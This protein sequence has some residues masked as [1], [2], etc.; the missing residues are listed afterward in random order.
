[1]TVSLLHY[2]NGIKYKLQEHL[3]SVEIIFPSLLKYCPNNIVRIVS[4]VKNRT[5]LREYQAGI[6]GSTVVFLRILHPL[7]N[8]KYRVC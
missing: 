1:M 2:R 3:C 5:L 6:S 7:K 8:S 4:F